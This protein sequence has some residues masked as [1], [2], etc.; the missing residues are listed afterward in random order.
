MGCIALDITGELPGYLS[1]SAGLQF[2]NIPDGLSAIS[3]VPAAGW[4][5]TVAYCAFCALSQ[6]QSPGTAAAAVEF[7]LKILTLRN[8]ADY[9][10]PEVH[11]IPPELTGKLPGYLPP[12]AG[13]TFAPSRTA[14]APSPRCRRRAGVRPLLTV[15]SASYPTSSP[16]HRG[17][18]R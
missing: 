7:G 9:D 17:S 3:T 16:R 4:G 12:S 1:P 18:G 5:Q 8:S 2:A 10:A 14:S 6:E 13:L 11:S 15:P